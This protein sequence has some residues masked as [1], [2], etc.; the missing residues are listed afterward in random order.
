MEAGVQLA[1]LQQKLNTQNIANLETPGYKSKSLVFRDLLKEETK[2]KREITAVQA[3]VVQDES[4]SIRP[5][6]NNV[7]YEA[8]S[9]ALYKSYVQHTMLLSKIKGSFENYGY[10]LNS[11]MK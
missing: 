4:A 10:V 6:G 1:Q 2:G 7:D 11:S 8:E 9:V 3:S 5:D